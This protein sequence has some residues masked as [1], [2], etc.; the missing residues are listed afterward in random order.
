MIKPIGS[1]HYTQFMKAL[2]FC[3]ALC[4]VGINLP[5]QTGSTPKTDLEVQRITG[6]PFWPSTT[7]M[8]C[9][10]NTSSLSITSC[11]G[12]TP[13]NGDNDPEDGAFMRWEATGGG[14]YYSRI[15]TLND[16]FEITTSTVAGPGDQT[17][18]FA[19]QPDGTSFA[20]EIFVGD[21]IRNNCIPLGTYTV[22]VWDVQDFDGDLQPDRDAT[23]AIIGCFVECTYDFRPSCA[24]ADEL[25]FTVEAFDIGCNGSGGSIRLYDF[26]TRNMYCI[27]EDGGGT[28]IT[29]SGPNGFTSNSTFIQNLEPGVYEVIV[30]DVYDCSAY[31]ARNIVQLDNVAFECAAVSIPTTIGGSDGVASVNITAGLD[32]Y[33]LYWE[34]PATDSL[35]N[36][37]D[38]TTTITGLPSGDYT[39]TVVDN[40]SSCVETCVL[41]IP[42]PDC[43]DLTAMV[44]EQR[45]GDCDGTLN[46]RIE[47]SFAGDFN[48]VLSWEG[49]GVDGS[50]ATVLDDLGPGTYTYTVT[51]SRN[52]SV[53]APVVIISEPSFTFNCGGVDE[54][55]PFLDDGQIG[56]TLSDGTP[57]FILSYTAIDQMGNPLPAVD[58]LPVAN[59]DTLRP[60]PAG[61]YFMEITDQTG[62]TRTCVATI[63]EANC[64]IFP[65]CT[66]ENPIS[67][68]G[69]G[70]VV[71]NFDSGPDWF[72][73]IL[74]PKDT[75]FVSSVATVEVPG[76]PQGDYNVSVYNTEGCTGSC[77]FSIIPPPCTL[78]ATSSFTSPRCNGERNGSIRLDITGLGNG[79]I[80]DWNVDAYDGL[81][82]A[83]DLPAGT[84]EIRISDETDCPLDSIRITLVD[85]DPFSVDLSLA[86]PILCF[87]DSTGGI[88][89]TTSGGVGP[90]VYDWSVDSLPDTNRVGNLI[91]GTY[92]VEVT[93]AN[94]C[95]A[96]DNL[97]ITQPRLLTMSCSATAET[98][99]NSMDGTISVGN[100]G[101]GDV[102]RLSGDL[103]DFT[104]T[105]ND[106]TTFTNL[107]PGTYELIIT[108]LNGCTTSCTA[109]VNPGPCMIG[110][111]T[112]T[113][114]PD[115]D[116]ALGSATGQVTNPF[117]TVNYLWSNG[118]TTAVAD[119]LVGGS[120]RLTVTDASGCEATSRV[121]ISPFTDMPSLTSSG[122][123]R[124]CD[125]G[126]T[127]LQLSLSGTAPFT[128]RYAFSQGGGA[129]Q[130]RTINRT[131]SGM[132]T[133]CPADLGLTDLTGVT[134]RLIDV[135]D[136]NGCSRPADRLLPVFVYPP[137]IG[138]IDTTLCPGERL[139]LYGEI[140]NVSR[141][142]GEIII[143]VPSVN[144]CDST[145]RVNLQY[146][147]PAFSALDTMLCIGDQLLF[148]GQTFNANRRAGQVLLP[149]PSANGC[150]STVFV[151]VGFHPPAFGRLDTV[152]CPGDRLNYFGQIF[153]ENR[154]SGSVVVPIL[155]A[156]GCDSTVMVNVDFHEPA[157]G[158]LDTIICND[159][160][161]NYYGQ[162]FDANRLSGTLRLPIP[163]SN[164]CDTT[165]TV[166]IGFHP[167]TTGTFD[168]SLCVGET[169]QFGD[170]FFEGPAN[171]VLTRLDIPDQYGC[172]SLVFVT[173][174][175][176]PE[177]T[178]MLEGDGIICPGEELEI[179]LTYSGLDTVLVTLTSDPDE[180]ISLIPGTTTLSRL[181]T[182]GTRVRILSVVGGGRCQAVGMGEIRVRESDLSADI[183]VLSGDAVFAV[184]CADGE[185]GALVAV[186]FGGTAPY[187]FMWSTGDESAVLRDLPPGEYNVS[188]TSA[189]GCQV[190]ARVG[191]E[192]PPPLTLVAGEIEANCTDT[193]PSIILRDLQGGIGPYLY[194]TNHDPAYR[195]PMTLPDTVRLP[196]GM[197]LLEIEDSNGCLLR[198]RF[199][200]APPPVGELMA[201]PRR[202]II[203]EGDSVRIQ[204]STNLEVPGYRMVPGPDSLITT[205]SFFVTPEWRT[206]YGFTATDT[207]GC[208]AT[209]EI[210]IFIDNLVP[211]YVPNVFS[212][213]NG[214]GT[215]DLFKAYAGRRVIGF[216]DF[217]IFSRWGELIYKDERRVGP[218][219][220]NWGW[221]GHHKDERIYEQHVYIYKV[222]VHL[223]G[224]RTE[225]LSGDV[226]L[227]R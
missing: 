132:E 122:L 204:L 57:P 82:V 81:W 137:A 214:D 208:S 92:S 75:T 65:N 33:N 22:Q 170:V 144:G 133:I 10:P 162:F 73:T 130:I 52:C 87:G 114:Q 184:S 121:I 61:A 141:P 118:D 3:F 192:A 198:E 99:V 213:A 225:Y 148:F 217:F 96:T 54:T 175:Q 18:F 146:F 60:L 21:N 187:T 95:V 89:A 66:P 55:L 29:W 210:E 223:D 143:P 147:A 93:D 113:S 173:V 9:D 227:L 25:Y 45:N 30:E 186:P 157:I 158:F 149:L 201:T 194:R 53:S 79:L 102:V 85:P 36:V 49:P 105:S 69:N 50:S 86:S 11:E 108:D 197:T 74:G 220:P 70:N 191:L 159:T 190:V 179:S 4:L 19:N 98:L 206:T 115:C 177:P 83:N 196:V 124:V 28:T 2:L 90:L 80:V 17:T 129:E 117:G 24:F 12:E 209:A 32:N 163:S 156:T 216:S 153:H 110:L 39:F 195:S 199:G 154:R 176:L 150:D 109:I 126:C 34:G 56:I 63:G 211:V 41:N 77:T 221:D 182:A 116:N 40:V 72:V 171:N 37:G 100:A 76:L 68:L 51:D 203:P 14:L 140:F 165:V 128:I 172:D 155:S 103:G 152:L 97:I 218:N 13:L 84:Y 62:C 219:E 35:L 185:D 88:L 15:Y 104:L 123:S 174:T 48:P 167:Q 6:Q 138:L 215:N 134:L 145:V 183:N 64:D 31:W 26:Q 181:V 106:D 42:E 222:T 135:T 44:V 151:T 224:G 207:T 27:D 107:S 226:L 94:G 212:P 1:E 46:G 78:A 164:G 91:V 38:G 188:V 178:V 180:V 8:L 119:S 47:I 131:G 67:V 7:K 189:R 169:L 125:D 168:T 71:L 23:G 101:A 136:V 161:L 16:T 43:S 111:T 59:G 166:T 142:T 160:R 202:A 112:T 58:S 139:N 5:A 200:F 20:T 205:S 193:L 120:Y 127:I